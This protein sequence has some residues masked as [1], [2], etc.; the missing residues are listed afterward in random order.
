MDTLENKLVKYVSSITLDDFSDKIITESKIRLIDTFAVALFAFNEKPVQNVRKMS[1][2]TTSTDYSS[3]LWGTSEKVFPDRASFANGCAVR[4]LDYNDTYLSKEALHPSDAIPAI[5]AVAE[6]ENLSGSK[7]IEGLIVS[8]EIACRLADAS[9]IRDRGWDHVAYISISSALGAAKSLDLSDDEI[10]NALSIAAV[11]NNNLRQTRKGELSMWKG[12]AAANASRNG[13]W[14]ALLAK[15]GITGPYDIFEGE[16]GF[17]NQISGPL[18]ILDLGGINN[19]NFKISET[20][21]K[22]YPV[23]YH[24]MSAVTATLDV[25]NQ[26]QN[27]NDIESITLETF[28]VSYQIIGGEKEKWL[29][30]TRE[31]AD[32]SLPYIISAVLVDGVIS[33]EQFSENKFTD[34]KIL[35][36]LKKI[37][38]NENQ[39]YTDRYPGDILN[40][41]IVRLNDGKIIKSE[42]AIPPGHFK[43]PYSIS[44]IS[45]KFKNSTSHLFSKR[46]IESILNRLISFDTE[47]DISNFLSLLD[48]S[49]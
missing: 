22:C 43:Q 31:T 24:A 32:H 18:N 25:R 10:R 41:V 4:Y 7:V 40:N 37:N 23:E 9:S 39:S 13:V 8:Y 3:T 46:Q 36:L 35:N 30:K 47:Y 29:P 5:L 27:I 12:F 42:C 26:I 17:I 49:G 16:K 45:L 14:A 1:L 11:S 20:S 15:N 48:V 44:D 19:A 28:K 33:P 38:V 34:P 6:A 21:I 2:L